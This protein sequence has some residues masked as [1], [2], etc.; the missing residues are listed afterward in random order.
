MLTIA[1]PS[2]RVPLCNEHR[3]DAIAV[4]SVEVT[5]RA[6]VDIGRSWPWF[7]P[8]FTPCKVFESLGRAIGAALADLWSVNPI[9]SDA[10]GS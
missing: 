9:E 8:Y 1:S 7:D 10:C 4:R 2:D 5:Q 6:L 3:V